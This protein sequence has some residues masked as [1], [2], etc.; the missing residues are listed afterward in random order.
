LIAALLLLAAPIV[1]PLDVQGTRF[2]VPLRGAVVCCEDAKDNGWP[3]VSIKAL[4]R[5]AREGVNWTH[6]RLGP[7]PPAA[8][9]PEYAAYLADG[10]WNP[11]FWQRVRAL[12]AEAARLGVY[13]EVDV[14]DAWAFEHGRIAFGE[15]CEVM[16]HAP[17]RH[18][19]KWVRKVAAETGTFP[20]VMYQVG[21]ETF[22]CEASRAWEVGV[23][24]ALRAALPAGRRLIGTNVQDPEIEAEFDYAA[25]HVD[26]AQSPAGRPVIVNEY[27][28]LTPLQFQEQL[29]AAE[30]LG[31]TFV[32][33]RGTMNGRQWTRALRFL[34]EGTGR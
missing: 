9:G 12:L 29:A 32:L 31:S 34:R 1:Q 27:R 25:R 28:P 18:H 10:S 11:R 24:D 5:M 3:L 2:T 15:G 22:D 4:R 30:R 8:E 14:M 19:L 20:N 17:Q 7:Y 23:R 21:N 13:V 16:A 33:W 26:E 6:V